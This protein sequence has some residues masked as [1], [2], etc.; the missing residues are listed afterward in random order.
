M[1]LLYFD[2]ETT[3]IDAVK[4]EIVQIAGLIEV[5]GTVVEEFNF[6]CQPTDWDNVDPEALKVTGLTIEELKTYDTPEMAGREL[7][8]VFD[9]YID[10]YNKKDKFYPA[11]HNVSFDLD[12]LQAF[13]KKHVDPYGIGSYQNWRAID[14]RVIANFFAFSGML[15]CKDVKLGTLCEIY[16]IELDAHDALN[17]IRACR[18]LLQEF[19]KH[20]TNQTQ[21]M[22]QLEMLM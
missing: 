12:F 6:R 17:D 22:G 4:N 1:K 15:D 5:D 19:Q 13:W 3:G 7:K 2:T 8:K 9:K 11:G 21:G 14:T 10:K 16:G 18:T 20:L